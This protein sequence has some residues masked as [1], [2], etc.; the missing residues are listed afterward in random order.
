VVGTLEMS[1]TSMVIAFEVES[2]TA[3]DLLDTTNPD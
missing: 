3:T 2:E 1:K